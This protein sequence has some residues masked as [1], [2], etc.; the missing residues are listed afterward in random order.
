[1]TKQLKLVI[2][3]GNTWAKIAVFRGDKILEIVSTEK[4]L[5]NH[6]QNILT[7]YTTIQ[8]A[9]LSAVKPYAAEVDT[10]LTTHLS[11]LKLDASTPLPVKNLYASPQTLGKDRLA[12]AVAGHS[13]FPGE[14]V[15][16]IVA[17]TTITYDF[18]NHKGEYLGGA[19]SPG[20][21][22]RL[23]ALHS[24]TGQLPLIGV[25]PETPVALVGNNTTA[26][27]SSGVINGTIAEIEGIIT[28]YR[29]EFE[30]LKVVLGGGDYKYFDKRLKNNIF[31]APNIVLAGLNEILNFN[32]EK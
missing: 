14:N 30:G 19:I 3:I 26:A 10:L 27:I 22:L 6:I 15:L 7:K 28:K 21:H 17:G 25:S 12:I 11:F 1:M 23:H 8:S 4:L 24:F 13:L 32:E 16:A 20:I 2:D 5:P 18:V 29:A 9:I 31:A